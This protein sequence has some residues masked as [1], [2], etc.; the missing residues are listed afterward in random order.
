MS[1]LPVPGEFKDSPS[2][3]FTLVIILFR[4]IAVFVLVLVPSIIQKTTEKQGQ[5]HLPQGF[6]IC[7][8]LGKIHSIPAQFSF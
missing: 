3:S 6:L 4:L 7:A 8:K 5:G 1:Y 2:E